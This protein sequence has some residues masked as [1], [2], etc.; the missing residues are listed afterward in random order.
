M[1]QK[2]IDDYILGTNY[3]ELERLGH[4]HKVWRSAAL[5]VWKESGVKSGSKII[6]FGAGPGFA[7]F[8]LA[9]I[10]G[11]NGK[12][13]ALER[14]KIFLEYLNSKKKKLNIE[15]IEIDLEKKI[16]PIKNFDFFWS[17]W[18]IAFLSNPEKIIKHLRGNLKIGGKA[19]FHEYVHYNTYQILPKINLVDEFVGHVVKN[20]R[21]GGG[22]PNI[23]NKVISLLEKNGFKIIHTK[24]LVYSAKPHSK[25]WNWP[26]GFI[27][28]HVNRLLELG[29][30]DKKWVKNILSEIN[31]AE[32]NPNSI[33]ITPMVLEIVAERIK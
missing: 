8:D 17:R 9:K 18:A 4:Q 24:P 1:E 14:S 15:A 10:V 31:R 2:N 27:R 30:V 12:V 21:S 23:A 20:W 6:D 16:V 7:S 11:P 29:N 22:E 5:K 13:V 33:L 19:I 26:V 32:K 3:D 28:V 25:F